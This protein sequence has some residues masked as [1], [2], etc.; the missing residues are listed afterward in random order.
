MGQVVFT[1]YTLPDG[2]KSRVTVPVTDEAERLA[3]KIAAAGFVFEVEQLRT[4]DLSFTIADD[5]QDVA[6]EL[7]F[8]DALR[9]E[10][11]ALPAIC[12]AASNMIEKFAEKEGFHDEDVHIE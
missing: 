5:E 7:L 3:K 12:K 8:A 9:E 1:K 6:I 4:G 2:R 10:A 11:A